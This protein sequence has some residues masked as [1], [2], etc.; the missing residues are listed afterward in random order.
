ML[1][2]T[3]QKESSPLYDQNSILSR[4]QGQYSTW[5]LS[6][7][8]LQ[9]SNAASPFVH[10]HSLAASIG[11]SYVVHLELASLTN[12]CGFYLM[13]EFSRHSTQVF[14]STKCLISSAEKCK[15]AALRA[16]R[17]YTLACLTAIYSSATRIAKSFYCN[18]AN[19]ST[20][21]FFV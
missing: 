11:Y 17:E 5:G 9:C 16:M 8:R 12:L 4:D 3:L 2:S 6:D 19:D 10:S 13:I 15:L 7:K 1:C 21:S 14:D 20:L 18:L